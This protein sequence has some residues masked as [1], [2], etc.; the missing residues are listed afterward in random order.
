M[1]FD[2]LRTEVDN[3]L[4]AALQSETGGFEPVAGVHL[5]RHRQPTPLKATLYE[6]VVC[7]ILHGRKEVIAGD[8]SVVVG[9]GQALVVSHEI[10]VISKITVAR[11]SEPYVAVVVRLQLSVLRSLYDEVGEMNWKDASPSTLTVHEASP[12]LTDTIN[13]YLK[14]SD[15]PIAQQVLESSIR[16]ELHFRLLMSPHGAMLRTLQ[17][18]GSNASLIAKAI[19]YLRRN[20][21]ETLRVEDVAREVGLSQAA[22]HKHFKTVTRTTPLQF[23]KDLRLLGARRLLHEGQESVARIAHHVG[24]E[25]PSQFSREYTRKF[26]I[27]PSRENQSQDELVVDSA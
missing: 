25:S 12:Q 19:N 13:R 22:L 16:K 17:N 21:R 23:Q 14:L 20:Y 27:P 1:A 4:S 24:Y 15:D 3:R 6:P 5:L 7:L 8:E 10:P 9:P 2:E 11:P 18:H 26:G